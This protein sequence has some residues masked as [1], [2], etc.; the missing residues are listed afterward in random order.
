MD[1]TRSQSTESA[2]VS[3]AAPELMEA[4]QVADIEHPVQLLFAYALTHVSESS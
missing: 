4:S 3:S 1:F 2:V